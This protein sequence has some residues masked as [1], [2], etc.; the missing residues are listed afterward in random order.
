[1]ATHATVEE[2]LKRLGVDPAGA[3]ADGEELQHNRWL[4]P[5][6]WRIRTGNG[7]RAVLK[8]AQVGRPRGETAWD[9]HWTANDLDP[10]RWTYWCRE[11]LAY[12][13]DLPAAY[14]GSGIV[15]PTCLALDVSDTDAALLLE[16]VDGR[17][18]EFWPVAGHRPA[19][20]ALGRAQAPF[21]TGR[22]LPAAG[23]LTRSFL[24]EYSSEKPA[25]WQLLDDDE[26]WAHPVVRENFPPGLREAVQL[27]H[28][29]R[30]RLY[31][32]SESLPRTLCHLDFWPK[33]LLRRADGQIVLL[34]W[35]FAGVG[36]IGEDPGN[37]VPDSVFDHFIPAAE[38]PDLEQAVFEGYLAGL[39]EAGWDGRDSEARL[40]MVA[41][42]VKYAWLLPLMLQ[43]AADETHGAYHQPADSAALYRARGISLAFL[44]G[45]LDEALALAGQAG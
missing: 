10:H 13:S 8:Y 20:E 25:P 28:A 3:D 43:R 40:G 1:M 31:Q 22:E 17:P 33:N 18:G 2:L 6:V 19:A 15:A 44:T 34:D 39:R 5:G 30:E 45:W 24:R 11:P 41:S 9:A 7:Q 32:I 29:N 26:T 4:S 12:Q 36:A 35:A 37:L 38:M 42:C 27:V 21:L 14:A 23:W 16:W